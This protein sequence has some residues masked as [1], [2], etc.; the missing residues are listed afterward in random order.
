MKL[1]KILAAFF[2]GKGKAATENDEI[3]QEHLTEMEG[4]AQENE[5]LTQRVS[6]LDAALNTATASLND[7]VKKSGEL[8]TSLDAATKDRD[9]WKTKAEQYGSQPG[10]THTQVKTDGERETKKDEILSP[11]DEEARKLQAEMNS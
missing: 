6:D 2:S 9:E 4:V 8:Q 5:R 11:V 1:G 7:A 10:A 3:T